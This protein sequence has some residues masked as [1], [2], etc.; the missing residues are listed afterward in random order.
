M[1]SPRL[2]WPLGF[3]LYWYQHIGCWLNWFKWIKFKSYVS[4]AG[5]CCCDA[6][7]ECCSTPSSD[8]WPRWSLCKW[9]LLFMRALFLSPDTVHSFSYW[10]LFSSSKDLSA[11]WRV[12]WRQFQ[13]DKRMD[14]PGHLQQ[15]VTTGNATVAVSSNLVWLK[16][17]P[18]HTCGL[19][20]EKKWRRC[21]ELDSSP[22]VFSSLV[23]HVLPGAVLQS[24]ERRTGSNQAGG[25]IPVCQNGGVRL[26]LVSLGMLSGRNGVTVY[27]TCDGLRSLALYWLG[28]LGISSRQA[29]FIALLVKVGVISE[30]RTWDWNS[31][32]AV[33]TGLQVSRSGSRLMSTWLTRED[34]ANVWVW[35]WHQ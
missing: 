13:F 7:W 35:S 2:L 31:V 11:V 28:G 32:E 14:V 8:P 21:V 19:F 30:R 3:E 16:Q 17:R 29:V 20:R 10:L 25:Q 22:P 24:S 27:R 6:N 23:C 12:R 9:A 4:S 1:L 26:L 34:N 15:H 5:F 18:Y 33:A